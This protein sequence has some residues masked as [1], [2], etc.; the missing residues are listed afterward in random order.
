MMGTLF[1]LATEA[2]EAAE[3]GFGLNLD[4]LNTNLLNLAILVGVLIYFGRN[5]LGKILSERR[6]KIAQEIQEAESRASNA[7]K[8]LA[9]EQEKLAQAKAE[10]Q[11]ILAASNERAEAA[12][13]AIAVQTEKDI[14]R[15]KA[16]AA[17]D[18]STEQER[19]I[20]E[21]RQ[22]VAAM[23]LERVESTLKNTLDDSTQQQ[24]INKTIASLGG[25]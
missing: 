14:E 15:L 22:R 6:E 16:T 4:I 13:Q 11:R 19:V 9:Q 20:T 24:L 5:S 2:S 18:L 1:I 17:Q 12:K 23:A 7:A 25:S 21:L 10:A 8:A 3:S